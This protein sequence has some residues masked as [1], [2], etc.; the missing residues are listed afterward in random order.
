MSKYLNAVETAK[1]ILEASGCEYDAEY[2]WYC[3]IY[4]K[5]G[6]YEM[7]A[8]N[9][10]AVIDES[11]NSHINWYDDSRKSGEI[12]V[13]NYHRNNVTLVEIEFVESQKVNEDD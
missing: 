6:Y 13:S 8:D 1:S 9:A 7:D 4:G 5:L 3:M 12:E 11:L 10:E 2:G